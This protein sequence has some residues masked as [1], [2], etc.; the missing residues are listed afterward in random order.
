MSM[1]FLHGLLKTY[2]NTLT[3]VVGPTTLTGKRGTLP[4]PSP[5][6]G[7]SVWLAKNGLDTNPGRE[8]SPK[9]T[10]AAAALAL[11]GPLLNIQI[12]RNGYV[13]DL[14]FTVSTTVTLPANATVQ[15]EEGEI[16]VLEHITTSG[17]TECGT[18]NVFNGISFVSLDDAT[19]YFLKLNGAGS[20]TVTLQNCSLV[21][22]LLAVNW[23]FVSNQAALIV[24]YCYFNVRQGAI[25][26]TDS[27]TSVKNSIFIFNNGNVVPGI[28]YWAFQFEDAVAG[29]RRL[30][31][32]RCIFYGFFD[33]NTLAAPVLLNDNTQ[34]VPASA[35]TLEL[36][37]CVI[38]NCGYVFIAAE[39]TSGTSYHK[40]EYR[41][42]YL[43]I[44]IAQFG[45][46]EFT[47]GDA[48]ISIVINDT[49]DPTLPRMYTDEAAGIG[50]SPGDVNGFRLQIE[51][52]DTPDGGGKYLLSSPFLG[53]GF[54][55]E[56]I[57]PFD[58]TVTG[59]TL[60][61]ADSTTIVWDPR[62]LAISVTPINPVEITDV[63]GSYHNTYDGLRRSFAFQFEA[64]ANNENARKLVKIMADKGSVKFYPLGIA[65][66]GLFTDAIEG[67]FDTADNS[68]AP[69]TDLG[70]LIP[71]NWQGFWIETDGNDYYIES[72]DATKFVLID[73]LNVGFPTSGVH[74]FKVRYILVQ[75]Q[76]S[77]IVFQQDNFTAFTRG[78]TWRE[79][80]DTQSAPFEYD[81]FSITFLETED[82]VENV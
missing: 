16:A 46:I 10:Y 13:G 70:Y 43:A 44:I 3:R 76:R 79:K 25:L 8:A 15:V 32:T 47:L 63:R 27:K 11:G 50:N 33:A 36:R 73:K 1:E 54:S 38:F 40:I 56:D 49:L 78:G 51:G 67:F 28:S 82:L 59:P 66:Q 29:S 71:A 55:G 52:K 26:P 72:N 12:F 9:L 6:D 81:G 17:H 80:A 34:T 64:Y 68:F 69:S 24:Q 5:T 20:Y 39:A 65:G 2:V 31:F 7:N 18:D 19:P 37:S 53:A 4:Q 62:S 48:V 30:I 45:L 42:S 41:L 23:D 21:T 74:S 14:N 22:T 75:P 35:H 61:F 57:A 60:S 77:E 58:E